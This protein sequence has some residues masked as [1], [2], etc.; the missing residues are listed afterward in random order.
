MNRNSPDY[1]VEPSTEASI[2]DV[3][4]LIAYIRALPQPTVSNHEPRVQPIITPRFAISCTDDLL[5]G[6]GD[7]A[8]SEPN[9]RIQTHIAE[10][11]SEVSYTRGLFPSANNYAGVYDMFGLLRN[12]TILAHAVYLSEDEMNLIKARDAG[13]SHCPTS[14]FHLSS[15]I[16]PVGVFLDKGIKVIRTIRYRSRFT[17]AIFIRSRSA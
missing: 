15:G 16:A 1:Y 2:R 10:N 5:T 17:K 7:L 14:N 3:R 11:P 4:E 6:L 13:I 12:N 9:V 8:A